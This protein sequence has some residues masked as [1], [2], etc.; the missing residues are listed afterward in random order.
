VNGRAFQPERAGTPNIMPVRAF[1]GLGFHRS[2]SG[3]CVRNDTPYVHA[4]FVVA[5]DCPYGYNLGPY[6]RCT[7]L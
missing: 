2:A 1:C 4:P 6:G 7:R 5:R 3:R